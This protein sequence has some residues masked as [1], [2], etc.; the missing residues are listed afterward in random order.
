MVSPTSKSA[1]VPVNAWRPARLS[2][3]ARLA[4]RPLSVV[5]PPAAA[6]LLMG[7]SCRADTPSLSEPDSVC[8]MAE[9]AVADAPSLPHGV[10]TVL[11]AALPSVC[12][13]ALI[14]CQLPP[15]FV[16]ARMWRFSR[17]T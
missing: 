3:I 15:V 10:R 7:D 12:G 13:S 16:M 17:Y 6:V 2:D 14:V 4:A 1:A 8:G 9:A 11:A 5:A